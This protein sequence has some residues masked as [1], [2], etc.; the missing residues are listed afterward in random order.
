MGRTSKFKKGDR[1]AVR[2]GALGNHYEGEVV[3][4]CRGPRT[5]KGYYAENTICCLLII[6]FFIGPPESLFQYTV[7][8]DNKDVSENPQK[9]L[10]SSRLELRSTS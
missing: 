7:R 4:V 2:C 3:E 8:F 10:S 9:G 6:D 1:V 5:G